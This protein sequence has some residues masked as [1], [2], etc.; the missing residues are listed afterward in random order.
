L[1]RLEIIHNGS[2]LRVVSDSNGS[3]TL[4]IDIK[5]TVA[6]VGW[7]AARCF[8]RPGKAVRFAHTSPVYL[9]K[10]QQVR[11]AAADVQFFIDWIDREIRYYSE[12]GDFQALEHLHDVLSFY[13]KAER[14]YRALLK[15]ALRGGDSHQRPPVRNSLSYAGANPMT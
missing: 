11:I 9:Q 6:D 1:D 13:R 3:G 2:V 5:T 10:G 15:S 8:E 12:S 14:F 4:A 7:V